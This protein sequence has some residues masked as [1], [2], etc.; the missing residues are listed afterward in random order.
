MK[1]VGCPSPPKI[2]RYSLPVPSL[3]AATV[4]RE[5]GGA[6]SADPHDATDQPEY[7]P[8]I[9]AE[10]VEREEDATHAEQRSQRDLAD[11]TRER[12]PAIPPRLSLGG[13]GGLHQLTAV[14]LGQWH[15]SECGVQ[16]VRAWH[17]NRRVG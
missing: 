16:G 9:V 4:P 10:R 6:D 8:E 11:H 1:P 15:A 12:E 2:G 13:V 3:L 14:L 7:A 5:Q 17:Q